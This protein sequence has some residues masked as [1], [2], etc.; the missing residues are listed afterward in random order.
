MRR[1]W[2]RNRHWILRLAIFFIVLMVA[3]VSTTVMKALVK[4]AGFAFSVAALAALM[5]IQVVFY[6]GFVMYYLGGVKTIKI[7]PGQAG[8]VT[9]DD[10]WGQPELLAVARQWVELL[11]HP[12]KLREMGG[13]PV[14][15]VLLAGPPGS[16]KTY[17]A[18]ALAGEAA[19]PFLG[20]DG[21]R[22]ISMWLGVGSIKVMRLYAAARRYAKRYGA[23]IVFIDE[24]DSIGTTRGGVAG[25]QTQTGMLGSVPWFGAGVGVL[26]T[27]L[28]QLDGI[29]ES[30]GWLRT[31][32]YK[33]LGKK[34]PPP[35]YWVMTI[36]ATNR[37]DVLDPA[38]TRAGRLDIKIR[39]DPVDRQGRIE[40]IRGYLQRVKCLEE[41][42]VEG[43]ASDT[44]G[45][46][47]ADLMTI[48]VRRAPA[49]ALMHGRE[50]I[51]NADL[52]AALT[53]HSMGLRQPIAG[54]LEEDKRAIAFH[55]AGHAVATWALTKDR[56]TRASIIRYSGG[57]TGGASL[58]H[59]YHVPAEERVGAKVSDVAKQICVSLAS[60]AAEI[61]F[62]GQPHMGGSEDMMTVRRL[63][64]SLAENGVFSTLGYT[65]QPSNEL[66]K[67]MD[68]YMHRLL[69][70]TRRILRRHE[71]KVRA[72]VDALMEKEELNA[73]EVSEILGPRPFESEE[74]IE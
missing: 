36:G 39:V 62:L 14:T 57:P 42:D 4:L 30:R 50:G 31:R 19:V 34:L 5:I 53:E 6:F 22:L 71:D 27:L 67:E 54:I 26:N 12:E 33:L 28:T 20:I 59:I 24:L 64:L 11:S 58:G 18:K 23:C 55:E 60:R 47:P 13:Q 17:L 49:F 66:V 32:W 45:F 68:A 16:G 9:F 46:T 3:A 63:L 48:I 25:G 74:Q 1:W 8:E 29:N 72:L 43:F 35:D 52:H 70:F 15:G 65:P 21:S 69:E 2:R 37:P 7:M 73:Q 38:L 40:V 51:T 10:Y 44:I 61:E 56:I 41:I